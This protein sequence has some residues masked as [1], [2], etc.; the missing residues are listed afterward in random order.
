MESVDME[1]KLEALLLDGR[2]GSMQLHAS[3][4]KV[5]FT[6]CNTH[7]IFFDNNLIKEKSHSASLKFT[8]TST[9]EVIT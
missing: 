5:Y 2:D 4:L 1:A 6:I 3:L 9:Q 7:N 8:D